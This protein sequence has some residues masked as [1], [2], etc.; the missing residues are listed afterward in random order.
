VSEKSTSKTPDY[1][2]ESST[3]LI[4]TFFDLKCSVALAKPS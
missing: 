1:A 3:A 2:V 4:A